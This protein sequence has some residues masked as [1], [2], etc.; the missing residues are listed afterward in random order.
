MLVLI[1]DNTFFTPLDINQTKVR[2]LTCNFNF[3]SHGSLMLVKL[4]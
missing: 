1:D 2:R 3:S 4:R